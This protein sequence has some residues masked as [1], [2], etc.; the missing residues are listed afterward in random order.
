MLEHS[1]PY[2]FG[3]VYLLISPVV[4]KNVSKSNLLVSP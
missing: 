3:R 4:D 1:P 2:L